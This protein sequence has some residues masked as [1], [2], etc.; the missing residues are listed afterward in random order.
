M[1]DSSNSFTDIVIKT[2]VAFLL[3]IPL[4]SNPSEDQVFHYVDQAIDLNTVLY[5][6]GQRLK[7]RRENVEPLRISQVIDSCHRNQ[8]IYRVSATNFDDLVPLSDDFHFFS[9]N[10]CS[11]YEIISI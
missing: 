8:S 10:R 3:F 2:S 4:F 11:I 1:I 5:A 7:L 6:N 9:F